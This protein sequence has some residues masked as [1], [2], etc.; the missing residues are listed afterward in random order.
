MSD[1]QN[2]FEAFDAASKSD[3][4][5][6]VLKELK[7]RAIEELQWKAGEETTLPPFLHPEDGVSSVG[8]LV[9]QKEN[10]NW[11]IGEDIYV[12]DLATA[13]KAAL[14]ALKNGVESI[15]FVLPGGIDSLA[16]LQLLL[17]NIQPTFISIYFKL[18]D[19]TQVA[20]LVS[21]WMEYLKEKQVDQSAVKGG[22]SVDYFEA[23][24]TLDFALLQH[25]LAQ[26]D[27]VPSFSFLNVDHQIVETDF[28]AQLDAM[29]IT[30]AKGSEYLS[31]LNN[32]G[33]PVKL[34]SQ[35]LKFN[36]EVGNSY[37]VEIARLRAFQLLWQQVLEAYGQ[38]G[39][40]YIDARLSS[41]AYT[42]DPYSNMIRATAM[43]M[44]AVLGGVNRLTILPANAAQEIPSE[45]TRRVARNLQHLFKMESY[46]DRVIDPAAGSYYIENL[47]RQIGA[48]VW[49]RFQEIE[50][51]GGYLQMT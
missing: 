40:A 2:L 48:Q 24:A 16:E 19:A 5:Q 3:W 41:A 8:P 51:R 37:L 46:L 50:K 36:I 44:S 20:E 10:N 7:G 43:G 25:L 39:Q 1:Y 42:D 30:L 35:Q 11:E 23:E 49:K 26:S 31:S 12:E 27:T 45:F 17:Q 4:E 14:Q 21:Y 32:I 33:L 15:C 6:Q 34:L 47:T 29:A 13:N 18:M 28:D 38:K 9:L 22:I